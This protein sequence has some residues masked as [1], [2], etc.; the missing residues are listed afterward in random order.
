MKRI[1]C[2]KQYVGKAETSFN[3]R[4]NIYHKKVDAVMTWKHCLKEGHN[5]KKYPEFTTIHQLMNTC[6]F[7][8]TLIQPLIEGD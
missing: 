2:N 7:K 4:L 8:D 3:L 5:F 1:L 6:K